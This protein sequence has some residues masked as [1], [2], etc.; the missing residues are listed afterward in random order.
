MES[1]IR[2]LVS[3]FVRK[4]PESDPSGI[5]RAGSLEEDP[6][7]NKDISDTGGLPE[8][9]DPERTLGNDV[10]LR[11]GLTEASDPEKTLGNDVPL[12]GITVQVF[13]EGH[14]FGSEL[15]F[16]NR[17]HQHL[18]AHGLHLRREAYD[19]ISDRP[20]LLFC[21]VVSRVGT[22][23]S[24]ALEKIHGRKILLVVMHHVP[25]EN[26][27]LHNDS[28]GQVHNSSVICSVDCR[29]SQTSGLYNSTMN[30]SAVLSI[31]CV[32]QKQAEKS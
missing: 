21:P 7:Q 31:S 8:A 11:G 27:A 20:V 22:D 29:F 5:E 2:T 28:R 18:Q 6:S 9:S 17:L 32:V 10:P 12:R 16:L 13:V 3:Y 23:I 26:L 4:E 1:F 14:T 24:N 19:Q 15:Q 30:T 25:N